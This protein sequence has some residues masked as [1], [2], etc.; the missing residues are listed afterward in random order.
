MSGHRPARWLERVLGWA[1]P[2]GLSQQGSLGDLAEEFETRALVSPLRAHFWYAGQAASIL[3]YRMFGRREK[4][5]RPH[6]FDLRSDL[7]WAMRSILRRPAFAFGVVAVL[8]L[9]LGA[10]V[11][12]FSV[13]DGSLRNTSWWADTES[14]V[15]IWPGNLFSLG[16][17]EIPVR[18]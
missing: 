18:A 3:S 5:D 9:G 17:L 7:R 6:R 11:A 4:G 15:A 13:V 1:L 10:N 2:D 8:G 12:V 14:A 16:Q